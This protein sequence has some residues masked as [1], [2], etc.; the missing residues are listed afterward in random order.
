MG[1]HSNFNCLNFLGGRISFSAQNQHLGKSLGFSTTMERCPSGR[2]T[3][4]ERSARVKAPF[5]VIFLDTQISA[6]YQKQLTKGVK[7]EH[8]KSVVNRMLFLILFATTS[9]LT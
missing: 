2:A 3:V 9:V 8:Y 7:S 1:I 5:Q 6:T 4:Q